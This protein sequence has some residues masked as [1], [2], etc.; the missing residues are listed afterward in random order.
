MLARD[1]HLL[2]RRWIHLIGTCKISKLIS[3]KQFLVSLFST[4][5]KAICPPLFSTYLNI[6]LDMTIPFTDALVTDVVGGL[7]ILGAQLILHYWYGKF[8]CI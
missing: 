5:S 6:Q 4:S 7:A 8:L 1:Y 3:S 2:A